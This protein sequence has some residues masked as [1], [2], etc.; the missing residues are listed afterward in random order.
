MPAA[1]AL[2]TPFRPFAYDRT[3]PNR[4]R[5]QCLYSENMHENSYPRKLVVF[6]NHMF[7]CA[8][9]LRVFILVLTALLCLHCLSLCRF[10]SRSLSCRLSL[11]RSFSRS[12]IAVRTSIHTSTNNE[13]LHSVPIPSSTCRVPHLSHRQCQGSHL[14]RTWRV[15]QANQCQQSGS[16]SEL[17]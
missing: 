3:T 4:L 9:S 2:H 11:S 12:K 14:R 6:F 10:L 13:Q 15:L 7:V 17:V 16:Q 8:F 1:K 5:K